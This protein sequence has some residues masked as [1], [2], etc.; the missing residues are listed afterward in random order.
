MNALRSIMLAGVVLV[1]VPAVTVA[2]G[3]EKEVTGKDG[4]PMVLIPEGP[5]EMGAAGMQALEDERPRHRVMLDA[6]MMD[7]YE[8]T[9]VQYGAFLLATER[10]VPGPWARRRR[11][12][13]SP[14]IPYGWHR[15]PIPRFRLCAPSRPAARISTR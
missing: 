15:S 9:T 2:E 6:F 8:V 13:S 12:R 7:V 5:F 1:A 4:A 14:I 10:A 3:L 11:L